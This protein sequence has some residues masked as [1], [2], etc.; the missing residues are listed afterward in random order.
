[1]EAEQKV[2]Y[3]G[4]FVLKSLKEFL[5]RGQI[6]VILA[7]AGLCAPTA[8]FAHSTSIR[9][10]DPKSHVEVVGVAP[11]RVDLQVEILGLPTDEALEID[12]EV[13]RVH[14]DQSSGKGIQLEQF[15]FIKR[16]HLGSVVLTRTLRSPWLRRKSSSLASVPVIQTQVQVHWMQSGLHLSKKIIPELKSQMSVSSEGSTFAEIFQECR[17]FGWFQK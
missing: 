11:T 16:P 5:F 8:S 10:L 2:E 6:W 13:R 9:F 17:R 12:L 7:L 1:M 3:V 14:T 4:E 15:H